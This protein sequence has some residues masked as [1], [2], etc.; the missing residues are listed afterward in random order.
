M[1]DGMNDGMSDEPLVLPFDDPRCRRVELTGG[2]GAALA[3][4]TAA[5]LP[6]PPGFVITAGAFAATVDAGALR[7]AMRAGDADAAHTMVMV[8]TPPKELIGRHYEALIGRRDEAPTPPTA[9]AGRVAVRSSA[10]AEDSAGA[11]YAGQ[12]ETFLNTTGLD[13]VV[14][15]VVGCWA[16]FFSER[17]VFYRREK[18]SLDDVAMAVVV[19][20]MVDSHRSGVIFTMDPVHGRTDRMVVEAAYGLGEAV[21]SGE[22][23]PDHY[24]LDRRGAVKRRRIAGTAPVLDDGDCIELAKVGRR[25]AAM[26][27]A[28]QDVE[29]AFDADGTLFLLQSRPVTAI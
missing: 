19:Q 20:R 15:N 16:S 18:G 8:A 23:T 24:T 1:N 17:A 29:W 7:A 9:L 6:V 26:Y 14:A 13:D 3:T 21:V 4:M 12:Q 28:P 25:L 22:I 10:C 2:K 11:S 5:G 27:G